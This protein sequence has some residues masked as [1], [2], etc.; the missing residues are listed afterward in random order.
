MKSS[1]ASQFSRQE[2]KNRNR[3]GAMFV[4]RTIPRRAKQSCGPLRSLSI[5]TPPATFSEQ[6]MASDKR[7]QASGEVPDIRGDFESPFSIGG[8]FKEGRAAY[9]DYSATT[10]LD[11][12]VLDSMLPYMVSVMTSSSRVRT[13]CSQAITTDLT[14]SH[15]LVHM[16]IH[17]PEPTLLA[18]RLKVRQKNLV[19]R[20]LV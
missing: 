14:F 6:R 4:L 20:W 1:R 10:P 17:I 7:Y 9:L 11:P 15:R 18:G 16:V 2:H 13:I 5:Q 8:K 3:I 19:K 12:R